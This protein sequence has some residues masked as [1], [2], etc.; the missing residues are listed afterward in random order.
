MNPHT[1]R[2]AER[3]RP[4]SPG[5]V[6]ASRRP[7][8]RQRTGPPLPPGDDLSDGLAFSYPRGTAKAIIP[9]EFVLRLDGGWLAG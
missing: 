5:G 8:L 2:L 4:R 9:N 3:L 1:F 7:G 6:S